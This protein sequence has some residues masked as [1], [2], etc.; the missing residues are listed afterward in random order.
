MLTI[1]AEATDLSITIAY[2]SAVSKLKVFASF[3]S[4]CF[5]TIS[6]NSGLAS[7]SSSATIILLIG[8][9]LDTGIL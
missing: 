9:A 7:S 4:G 2:S 6:A 8:T 1:S 3:H 5:L